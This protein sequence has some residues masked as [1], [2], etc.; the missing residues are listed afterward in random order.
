MLLLFVVVNVVVA[1]VVV[2]NVVVGIHLL[3]L[4]TVRYN[5][6]NEY[7]PE[8]PAILSVC[9][10]CMLKY[11]QF[12]NLYPY[13]ELPYHQAAALATVSANVVSFSSIHNDVNKFIKYFLQYNFASDTSL[14]NAIQ[15]HRSLSN[16]SLSATMQQVD[17]LIKCDHIV[18][19]GGICRWNDEPF[20]PI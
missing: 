19:L 12:L 15:R 20:V 9:T 8:T 16:P 1:G 6:N 3:T 13:N 2:M 7:F 18:V 14:I 11:I 17:E 10:D 5:I 4:C